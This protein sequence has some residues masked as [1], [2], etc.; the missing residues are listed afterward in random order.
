MIPHLYEF[1]V[2][3]NS[4]LPL[5]SLPGAMEEEEDTLYDQILLFHSIK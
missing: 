4:V 5:I 1:P 2:R 3:E